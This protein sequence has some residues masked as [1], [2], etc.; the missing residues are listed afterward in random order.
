MNST[1]EIPSY[2]LLT[3]YFI[4]VELNEYSSYYI[5]VY[6]P[7]VTG[8]PRLPIRDDPRPHLGLAE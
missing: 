4:I 3:M 5:D 7:W 8:M 6:R 1:A 2:F